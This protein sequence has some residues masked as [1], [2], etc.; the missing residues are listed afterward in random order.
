MIVRSID[1]LRYKHMGEPL[2]V[3][4]SGPSLAHLQASDMP[5]GVVLAIN[6]AIVKVEKLMLSNVVYS[7]QKDQ[8]FAD[9][10]SPIIVH[11]PES[12]QIDGF[13]DYLFDCERDF[14]IPP[15]TPSVVVA[16]H[17][18]RWMGCES[19]VYHCCDSFRGDFRSFDGAEV[20]LDQRMYHYMQHPAMVER[21][22]LD[23]LMPWSYAPCAS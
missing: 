9:C 16:L 22:A 11:E 2:H 7:L 15:I 6:L 5:H 12:G 1:A 3:V 17:L 23:L 14:G 8:C 21:A 20:T 10:A 19:V 13:G 4:G 18:A